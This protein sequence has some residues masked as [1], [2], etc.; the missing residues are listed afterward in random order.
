MRPAAGSP[1]PSSPLTLADIVRHAYNKN[2]LL[3]N[4]SA[5]FSRTRTRSQARRSTHLQAITGITAGPNGSI[6]CRKLQQTCFWRHLQRV[7]FDNPDECSLFEIMT[8]TEYEKYVQTKHRAAIPEAALAVGIETTTT[9]VPHTSTTFST[10]TATAA[11]AATAASTTSPSSP[12]MQSNIPAAASSPCFT[13][14]EKTSIANT[15]NDHNPIESHKHTIDDDNDDDNDS[16]PTRLQILVC[17]T[18]RLARRHHVPQRR[19]LTRAQAQARSWACSDYR[20]H[21]HDGAA[22]L[23][24][25][26]S[27][28]RDT[29]SVQPTISVAHAALRARSFIA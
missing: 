23:T 13:S 2:I 27:V 24:H 6:L 12:I 16:L 10:P 1:T 9:T 11:T 22:Q 17:R 26:Y 20:L 19:S 5:A 25:K 4:P 21:L 18:P 3:T 7:F 15:K 28:L 8:V 14:M 29:V